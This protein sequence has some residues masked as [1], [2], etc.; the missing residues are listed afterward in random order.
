MGDL[1]LLH[2]QRGE[3][4]MTIEQLTDNILFSVSSISKNRTTFLYLAARNN[5]VINQTKRAHATTNICDNLY[6]APSLT[7]LTTPLLCLAGD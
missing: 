1:E 3:T 7:V 5:K 6:E 2:L 4:A